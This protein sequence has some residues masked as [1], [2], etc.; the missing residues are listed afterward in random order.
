MDQIGSRFKALQM[1]PLSDFSVL[2][3]RTWP[4]ETR[5][6]A[7]HGSVNIDNLVQHVAPV[8]TKEGIISIPKEFPAFKV[9]VH[10]LQTASV[11]AF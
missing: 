7:S 3:Y 5:D 6:L 11:E 2:D 10:K 9:H 8:I 1:S 4:I